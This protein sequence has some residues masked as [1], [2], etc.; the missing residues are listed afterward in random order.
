MSE[1]KSHTVWDLGTRLF[2]WV[3]VLCV[4][5][6]IG[7][8]LVILG[9]S[10]LGLSN[11]GKVALKTLHTW[12]G[13]VFV[14]NLLGR[15]VWGFVGNRYARWRAILPGGRGYLVAARRYLKAFL[16]GT[17][18]QYLGH[19]PLARPVMTLLFLLLVVQAG[20]G[21]LLAG[22]DLFYRPFGG[23]IAAWVAAPEVAP[24][25]LVP[26]APALYDTAAHESM[27]AFR[28]PF[29]LVHLY[30]FYMLLVLITLHVLAVVVTEI[31]E[32]GTLVS[33]MFTGRKV[34][35]GHAVDEVPG[36]GSGG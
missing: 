36:P 21:L 15:L 9:G 24:A 17:P 6:L 13:Y 26:Y 32:G 29:A 1:L 25:S 22:T 34:V 16:S 8:G 33:A 3:N 35:R 20:T 2:H 23:W 4:V 27:R 19:N 30:S 11:D 18:E 31:R 10:G 12:I 5:G 14:L 28:K 7:V